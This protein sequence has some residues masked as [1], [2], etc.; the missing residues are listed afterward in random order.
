MRCGTSCTGIE[1][2]RVGGRGYRCGVCED[3]MRVAAEMGLG[4]ISCCCQELRAETGIW[5]GFGLESGPCSRYA[6]WVFHVNRIYHPLA[7]S[8]AETEFPVGGR[9]RSDGQKRNN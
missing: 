6:P 9:W 4:S 1:S 5:G 3:E 8:K 2:V 7:V